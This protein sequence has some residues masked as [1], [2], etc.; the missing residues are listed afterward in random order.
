MSKEI[1]LAFLFGKTQIL[2]VFSV[3]VPQI[4]NT[5]VKTA[6]NVSKS[7]VQ[8]V[9]SSNFSNL[10]LLLDFCW[11]FFRAVVK[12]DFYV[13]RS[14]IWIMFFR[15]PPKKLAFLEI[16]QYTP[17]FCQKRLVSFVETAFYLYGEVLDGFETS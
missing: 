15:K 13:C 7:I 6:F 4:F 16:E 17:V 11:I 9:F 10:K 8:A 14:T 12:P 2:G 1:F 3:S 5:F